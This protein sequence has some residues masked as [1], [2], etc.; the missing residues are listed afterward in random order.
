MTGPDFGRGPPQRPSAIFDARRPN[1]A[2]T[3]ADPPLLFGL[4]LSASVP[5]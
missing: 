4:R 5:R 3:A 2:L 1:D